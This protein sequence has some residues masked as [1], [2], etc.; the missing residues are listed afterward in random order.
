MKKQNVHLY[1]FDSMSDWEAS[2]AVAGI[3]N[4]QF[5][6]NPGRY[7][8]KTVSLNKRLIKTIGGI[9]VQPDL[10]LEELLPSSSAMLVIPG[11]TAWEEG[12]NSEIIPIARVFLESGKPVAAICG[13]TA[14]LAKGGLLNDRKHT[15][16]AREYLEITQYSGGAFYE[17]STA[18]SDNNLITASGMAPL[19]FAYHIFKNLDIYSPA[20]LEAW[21]QLFKTGR[22]QYFHDLMEAVNA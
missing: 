10:T 22:P 11:G 7:E 9:S 20:V 16:N 12:K 21:Y 19:D 13:A 8:I 6:K 18:V 1:V 3:N 2:Y 5:Q 17:D 4:P 14:G 15:S